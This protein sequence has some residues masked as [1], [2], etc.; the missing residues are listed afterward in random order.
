MILLSNGHRLEYVAASGALAFDG[1]GWPWEWPMRWVGLLDPRCFTVVIKSLTRQPRAGNLRWYA[2]WRVVKMLPR[3]V[4]NAVGLTNP[5]L[6]WWC[7]RVGPLVA[8]FSHKLI[9]SFH[10]DTPHDAAEMTRRLQQFPLVA[11]ELN[12]SCP[13]TRE[14][15][16][17]DS[18]R[19]LALIEAARKVAQLPLIAKLAVTHDYR[20]IARAAHGMIEAI[21]INSVPWPMVFPDRPSPLATLGG[22][23]V[24]GAIAQ[25]YTWQM[26]QDL[27]GATNIPVIGPGIWE[28][29][30]LA[31]VRRLGAQAVS[32]GSVFLRYPW[33]PT[34]FVRRERKEYRDAH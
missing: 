20:A 28:Y 31:R 30:D 22:G 32:F 11:L 12:L 8:S 24:S 23:G 3:G 33:R 16:P 2:P 25:S 18:S 21:A 29:E 6:D 26:V 10:A 34:R 14:H 4:V 5:G 1:R 13:N 17:Q 15:A 27:A 19:V 7:R 9:G